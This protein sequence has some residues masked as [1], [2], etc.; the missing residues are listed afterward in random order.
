MPKP[1]PRSLNAPWVGFIIKWMAK[2]NTWIYRHSNGRLGGTFGNAPVA[3]LT[4]TG[5]KTG[6]PRV[7]PLLYLREGNRV[8]LVASKGGSDKNPLWYLNLKANPEVSVQIKDEVLRLRARDATEAEREE[9]WPKLDKM[10]PSFG[11]Y[12]SWTDR[13]IPIVICDP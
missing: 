8:V 5:R 10:Y 1:K 3:L 9:Y 4:T 6:E 12:R 2:G 13:V 7:S 11:D